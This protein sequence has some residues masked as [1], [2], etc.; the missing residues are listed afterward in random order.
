MVLKPLES[1]QQGQ[2]DAYT[3]HDV[4]VEQGDVIRKSST[5]FQRFLSMMKWTELPQHGDV[6]LPRS[7]HSI[8]AVGKNDCD[9]SKQVLVLWGGEH[10]PRVPVSS[11]TYIYVM[12]TGQWRKITDGCAPQPRVAHVAAAIEADQHVYLHGGRT[13]VAESSTLSD[14][15]RFDLGRGS[16]ETIVPAPGARPCGRNYHAAASMGKNFY[17]FGGCGSSGRLADLWRFDSGAGSWEELPSNNAI[18]ACWCRFKTTCVVYD[19]LA[20][21]KSISVSL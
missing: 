16:W 6:P 18:K 19:K 4:C 11:D 21:F 3:I 10:S 13:Q 15:Y 5:S 1:S 9:L 20:L 2:V 7:S 8:T 14:L 12:E 17:I